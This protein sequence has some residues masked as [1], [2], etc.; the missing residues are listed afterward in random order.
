[1]VYRSLIIV[2]SHYILYKRRK[3]KA[4]EFHGSKIKGTG[5]YALFAVR[6]EMVNIACI[7]SHPVV[8]LFYPELNR[9]ISLIQ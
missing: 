3:V 9:L 7:V 1:M 6:Y 2:R 5:V 4:E 8:N